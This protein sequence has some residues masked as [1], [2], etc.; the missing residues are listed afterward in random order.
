[1]KKYKLILTQKQQKYPHYHQVKIDKSEFLTGEEI[2]PPDQNRVIKQANF[3]YS[4]LGKMLEKQ[5][6]TIE[7][8]GEK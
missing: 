2:Q 5:I 1:M 3:P 7:I 6:K 4:L 8:Q